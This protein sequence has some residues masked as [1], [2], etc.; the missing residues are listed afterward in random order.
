MNIPA[1][2]SNRTERAL[3][4]AVIARKVSC[5]DKAE[6]GRDCWQILPSIGATRQQ[7]MM[8]FVEYL[9][10]YLPQQ[11]KHVQATGNYQV[12]TAH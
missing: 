9:C 11:A 7:Q 12:K 1:A 8:D 6:R 10:S 4:P 2:T 5:G 3:R